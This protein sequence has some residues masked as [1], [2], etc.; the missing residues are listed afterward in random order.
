[1]DQRDVEILLVQL[2]YPG[3]PRLESDVTRGWIRLYAQD[4]DRLEFN[5]RV[6]KGQELQPGITEAT[7]GQFEKIS[8]QRIDCVAWSGSFVD[9]VEVKDRAKASTLGQ[10]IGYRQLWTDE[11]PQN[12]VRRLIC[13]SP[14]I[15]QDA[16]RIFTANGVTFYEIQPEPRP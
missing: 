7:A 1:M 4:Y 9:I 11:H 5:V 14:F 6:G 16:Q 12:I 2:Q 15:D 3:M 8:R 10:L 13:V